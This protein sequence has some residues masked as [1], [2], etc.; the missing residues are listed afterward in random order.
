MQQGGWFQGNCRTA[1]TSVTHKQSAEAYDDPIQRPEIWA[2][3]AWIENL[4]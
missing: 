3:S 2:L 4:S 1:E